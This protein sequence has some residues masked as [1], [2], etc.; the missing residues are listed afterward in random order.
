VTVLDGIIGSD[1]PFPS[2]LLVEGTT[3]ATPATG[4]QRLFVDTADGL[5][6]LVDDG[7]TV[8]SIGGSAAAHIADTTAAHVA[9]SIGFTPTGT[10]AAT[11]VQAAIAEL[12]TEDA[13]V[14]I[15]DTTAA[16]VASSI[17]FTP[18]G[19]IAATDVQAA[20]QEVRDEASG[21]GAGAGTILAIKQYTPG[22]D[23]TVHN[24]TSTTS[25]DAD[26]TNLAVTFTV[27]ASGN[28]VVELNGWS[29]QNSS[30]VGYWQLRDST[31]VIAEWRM[32]ST[33]YG[34]GRTAVKALITG[35]TP[36][37]S[38]TYKWGHRV[39]AGNQDIY[40]GPLTGSFGP[41]VMIVYAAP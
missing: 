8:T 30:G 41:A 33:T 35:L 10:I 27:P 13:A 7:G 21:G 28:V 3:P 38:K 26:A 20:I 18:N 34:S 36:A 9:G 4:R 1:N 22:S 5:L 31:T 15:A 25:V 32:S 6:K 37:A 14:H 40:A 16:H 19:S 24:T 29:D 23:S 17:G 11:D 2:V 12:G 39:S